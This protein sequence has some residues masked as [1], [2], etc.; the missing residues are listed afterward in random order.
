MFEVLEA[1]ANT[2]TNLLGT[3]QF[4]TTVIGSL[5]TRKGAIKFHDEGHVISMPVEHYFKDWLTR[6]LRGYCLEKPVVAGINAPSEIG[7][8]TGRPERRFSEAIRYDIARGKRDFLNN[9]AKFKRKLM[10]NSLINV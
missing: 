4:S 5:W 2:L 10:G 7:T 3:Y 6:A 9:F 1:R 8:G